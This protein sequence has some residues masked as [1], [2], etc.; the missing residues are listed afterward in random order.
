MHISNHSHLLSHENYET[1]AVFGEIMIPT[2]G[3]FTIL[4][5]WK[6]SILTTLDRMIRNCRGRYQVWYEDREKAITFCCITS[7]MTDFTTVFESDEEVVATAKMMLKCEMTTK[8]HWSIFNNDDGI[9]PTQIAHR[10]LTNFRYAH[11]RA[12]DE[13]PIRTRLLTDDHKTYRDVNEMPNGGLMNMIRFVS[14]C[15]I[16]VMEK[17]SCH[18][19]AKAEGP[20]QFD[21]DPTSSRRRVQRYLRIC[22][23]FMNLL[24]V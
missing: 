6:Q 21:F 3:T 19:R 14:V 4:A 24:C 16:L 20:L 18:R 5:I 12:K 22:D 17:R 23:L 2:R 7:G 9:F 1:A 11:G 10:A 15:I 13:C 8:S